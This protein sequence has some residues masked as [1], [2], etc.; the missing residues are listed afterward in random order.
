MPIQQTYYL[1]TATLSSATGIFV[2]E[3]LT[4]LAPDGYYSDTIITR[5]MLG[6]VLY[7]AQ[8]CI[9]CYDSC[10]NAYF[11]SDSNGIYLLNVNMGSNVG[12]IIIDFDSASKPNGIK[13]IFNSQVYN[14]LSSDIDGV[15]QSTDPYGYTFTGLVSED[16]GISG[17]TYPSLPYY[18]IIDG[19]PVLQTTPQTL[20]VSPGDVS[21]ST[22]Y[23]PGKMVI[24]K[25]SAMASVLSLYIAGVCPG[26][27][28]GLSVYCPVVLPPY[29]SSNAV[30]S[31]GDTCTAPIVNEYYFV[32]LTGLATLSLYDYVFTDSNGQFPVPNG[33][34]GTYL[35]GAYFGIQVEN[36]VIV[37]ISSCDGCL[38][39]YICNTSEAT[40]DFAMRIYWTDCDGNPQNR[41][42]GVGECTCIQATASAFWTTFVVQWADMYTPA[43]TPGE[44][45]ITPNGC[46]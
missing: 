18:K 17:T 31:M 42:L 19:A 10:D 23:H 40:R 29:G 7:P 35:D 1:D 38:D 44:Y 45:T 33:F 25:P 20:V 5:Q 43:P 28:W 3:G 22:S 8:P 24:P 15:H 41:L 14:K 13:A 12:A 39:W 6:G 30:G 4:T 2:D 21:L 26:D 11:V 34:Y 16:C 9:G 37:D 46:L 36:G 27:T 32:S